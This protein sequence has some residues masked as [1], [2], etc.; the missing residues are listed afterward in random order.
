MVMSGQHKPNDSLIDPKQREIKDHSWRLRCPFQH[1]KPISRSSHWSDVELLALWKP[2]KLHYRCYWF[3]LWFFFAFRGPVLPSLTA[4]T[5]T[6]PDFR[7]TVWNLSFCLNSQKE[8][9]AWEISW[10]R[11]LSNVHCIFIQSGVDLD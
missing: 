1:K 7:L 8:S 3:T 5:W 11:H 6:N 4:S 2:W 9:L 10:C